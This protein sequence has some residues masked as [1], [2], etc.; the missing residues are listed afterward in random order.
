MAP[1]Q[2]V[3]GERSS[4]LDGRSLESLDRRARSGNALLN[5]GLEPDPCRVVVRVMPFTLQ[6][7]KQGSEFPKFPAE[8]P[9][10]L[11][12]LECFSCLA[13]MERAVC[14]QPCGRSA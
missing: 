14:A 12:A 11:F 5:I 10:L 9:H 7:D 4:V 2:D 8:T 6:F 3:R 13:V 1:E